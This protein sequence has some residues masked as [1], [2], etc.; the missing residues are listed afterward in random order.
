MRVSRHA[1]SRVNKPRLSQAEI[2][3]YYGGVLPRPKPFIV[4]TV[5]DG[6]CVI[7]NYR[8]VSFEHE[9]LGDAARWLKAK[10]RK[11][12]LGKWIYRG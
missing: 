5:N 8:I 9:S 1:L 12:S 3:R 2:D 6:V 11:T 10:Q 4:T 7:Y